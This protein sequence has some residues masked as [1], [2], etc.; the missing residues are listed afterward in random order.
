MR[1][2]SVLPA[3]IVVIAILAVGVVGAGIVAA[4]AADTAAVDTAAVDADTADTAD[5]TDT[6]DTA[7]TADNGTHPV[8]ETPA[9][10]ETE[11]D[12]ELVGCWNGVHHADDPAE[13][14]IDQDDG[15]TLSDEELT[16]LTHLK[17]ARVERI[18]DRPFQEEVP[19]EVVS[20][21]SFSDEQTGGESD[22]E[23]TR[24]ND[25]VWKALFV[26]G[27]NESS[28]PVIND[29]FA[30]SVGG[31]YSPAED[32][33]VVVVEDETAVRVSP[34]T[35]LH[36][37]GHAMQDQYGNLSDP[38]YTGATQDA[39]LAIDGVVEGEVTYMEEVYAERCGDEW[40]CPSE[41]SGDGAAN[42]GSDPNLG[43]LLV[44]L[45]PYSDGAPYIDELI[46]DEGWGA[47]DELFDDPP[48]TTRETIHREPFDPAQIAFNDT[49]TGGWETYEDP[50]VDGAETVGEAS[51]FV[52]M[53]YQSTNSDAD[54]IDRNALFD[55]DH[56]YRTYNYSHP[57]TDGWANDALY[58]YRNDA[59][60]EPRDGYV[61]VIEWETADDAKTFHDAYLRVLDANGAEQ[62]SDGIYHVTDG[63]FR[64]AYG[65][66]R[67][68]TTL[69]IVHALSPAEVF[70]IRPGIELDGSATDGADGRLDDGTDDG[71]DDGTDIG[72]DDGTD[73]ETD[74]DV[75]DGT[76]ADD[77]AATDDGGEASSDETGPTDDGSAADEAPGFG[78][79]AAF[80]ALFVVAALV[81]RR[82]IR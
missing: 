49:A 19:V 24:W 57:V 66:E 55:T 5:T 73:A 18:R 65:V 23:F 33:I 59:G 43:V 70:E 27:E 69:T 6:A 47:V 15:G 16:A 39:D 12:N 25:Q 44:V 31:F 76:A 21:E 10:C 80:A 82:S 60:D 14:G 45:Q 36:E 26:I 77:D 52:S 54:V 34:T 1:R 61:W 13:L 78:V 32:R 22:V 63:E 41:P 62:R 68:G 50:G 58:P 8:A 4:D 42:D 37:L 28:T 51:L 38:R 3:V 75:D 40:T 67:N 35:L 56:P 7:D 79:V 29:V 74:P 81:S 9:D 30:G 64:G 2:V 11:A 46:D 48:K 20:R 71:L 72:I 53:W 17:M